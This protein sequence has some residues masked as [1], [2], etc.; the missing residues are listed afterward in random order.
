ME[1]KK[2]LESRSLT[3]TSKE[4]EGQVWAQI[5]T[6]AYDPPIKSE[7]NGL[8]GDGGK[9]QSINASKPTDGEAGD[10]ELQVDVKDEPLQAEAT[11]KE[12]E[13]N[14][15]DIPEVKKNTL[16]D[17]FDTEL[18]SNITSKKKEERSRS[19]SRSRSR[20]RKKDDSFSR[21]RTNS[22]DPRQIRSR[23]F[24]GHL[25]TS[26]CKK[27]MLEKLFA[28]Y[29]KITGVNVQ[30]GYGFVQFE[31]EDSV[32]AAIKELHGTTFCGTKIGRCAWGLNWDKR[33]CWFK[34]A[35]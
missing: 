6:T 33:G 10:L 8:L 4:P 34:S 5:G 9:Q 15:S 1:E 11:E 20:E 22:H 29:G 19:R 3:H 25:N 23:V 28:P 30:N 24:V 31:E 35:Y 2:P 27:D 21:D 18:H 16:G 14:K 13:C 32:K 26:E 17:G 12:A 7:P